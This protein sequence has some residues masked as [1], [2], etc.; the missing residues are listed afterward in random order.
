MRWMVKRPELAHRM[1][2]LA[3][4]YSV[5]VVEHFARLFPPRDVL[6]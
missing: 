3:T 1:L 4:D 6:I 2:R 5:R